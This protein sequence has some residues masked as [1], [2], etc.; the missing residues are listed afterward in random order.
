MWHLNGSSSEREARLR[1]RAR[2]DALRAAPKF[3]QAL[4][5]RIMEE[6]DATELKRT[7]PVGRPALARD[8]SQAFAWRYS[9]IFPTALAAGI[10][11]AIGPGALRLIQSSAPEPTVVALEKPA[12][13]G[14]TDLKPRAAMLSIDQTARRVN[15]RVRDVVQ[16]AMVQ[17][18]W[19]GLDHDVRLATR[20]LVDQV[21][22]RAE[23]KADDAP[24]G[25]DGR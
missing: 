20:Y 21:P 23:W 11:L 6:I 1:A 16:T 18:Q 4:H 15:A 13:I 7:M 14:M 22:L 5:T 19:V 25:S 12:T 17:Q 24:D 8:A 3:S 10:A 9:W 2:R